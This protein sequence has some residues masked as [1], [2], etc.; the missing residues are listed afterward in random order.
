LNH[1]TGNLPKG[2]EIDVP[3]IYADYYLLEALVRKNKIEAN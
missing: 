1:S 3:I 2:S